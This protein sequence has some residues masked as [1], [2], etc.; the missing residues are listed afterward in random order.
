MSLYFH[1]LVRVLDAGDPNWRKN[2]VVL[3][4]NAP[5]HTA[6][7]TL[8]VLEDLSIPVLFT[9]PHSYDGAACEL[10]FAAFKREDINPRRIPTG[11]R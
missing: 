7:S 2:R 5:Y 3:L 8:K 9:G 6:P 10:F 4:D 1:S 11:K